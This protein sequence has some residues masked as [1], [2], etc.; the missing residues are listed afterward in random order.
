MIKTKTIEL[1]SKDFQTVAKIISELYSTSKTRTNFY[2]YK[3]TKS[4]S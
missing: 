2:N 1:S 4:L 3:M